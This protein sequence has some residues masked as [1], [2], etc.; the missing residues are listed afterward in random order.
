MKDIQGADT[1]I[2]GLKTVALMNIVLLLIDQM[3]MC[4]VTGIN[5]QKY[6]RLSIMIFYCYIHWQL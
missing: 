4:D 2:K 6:L 3:A 5:K 1:L